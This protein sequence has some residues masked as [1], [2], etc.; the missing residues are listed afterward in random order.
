M[1]FR[2]GGRAGVHEVEWN[3]R[4]SCWGEVLALK[5]VL[6]LNQSATRKMGRN[7]SGRVSALINLA[8][9]LQKARNPERDDPAKPILQF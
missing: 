6:A 2:A 4:I 9:Q 1:L 8:E 5:E 7:P 3:V